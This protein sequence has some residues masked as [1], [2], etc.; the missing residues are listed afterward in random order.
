MGHRMRLAFMAALP[1]A[2]LVPFRLV[3]PLMP[4]QS[5]SAIL[6]SLIC[7]RC[8]LRAEVCDRQFVTTENTESIE[9]PQRTQTEK[10]GDK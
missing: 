1:K 10:A 8:K 9:E 6:S 3:E 2:R 5:P 4:N 7:F